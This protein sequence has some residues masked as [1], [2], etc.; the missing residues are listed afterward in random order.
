M[1]GLWIRVNSPRR[2]DRWT[3]GFGVAT[4]IHWLVSFSVDVMFVESS[5]L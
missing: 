5:S 3:I 4:V 2:E 1:A